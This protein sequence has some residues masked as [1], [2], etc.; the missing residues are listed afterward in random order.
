MELIVSIFP[1]QGVDLLGK[2]Q[3]DLLNKSTPYGK[4][5]EKSETPETWKNGV[6]S[7]WISDR[8]TG[9][10]SSPTMLDLK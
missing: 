7:V 5:G 3:K 10:L 9:A 1:P 6:K 4:I 8:H 2:S